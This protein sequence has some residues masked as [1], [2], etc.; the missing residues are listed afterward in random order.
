MFI[1]D[2]PAML[3]NDCVIITDLH[4]GI[5]KELLHA[6]VKIPNQAKRLAD[7]ANRLQQITKAKNLVI[8][9]DIK[10]QI[11]NT[12]FAEVLEVTEFLTSLRFK[13]II[14]AKG[15]HDGN[16]ENLVKGLK[17]VSIRKS[18]AVGDYLLTHGHRNINTSKKN[19]VIGHNH[20]NVKLVDDLGASYIMPCWVIGRVKLKNVHKLIIMPSFSELSGM[21]IVNDR[22][23]ERFNGPIAKRME[24]DLARVY[25][26]DGTSLGRIRDIMMT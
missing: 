5:S 10:H 25:L 13:K 17:N 22:K 4:L 6:G 12:S 11:P 9:G 3:V 2:Y 24:K 19:I 26:Q 18:V 7:K 16:I 1:T 23:Y 15:N 21:M 20:P 8:L 14:I